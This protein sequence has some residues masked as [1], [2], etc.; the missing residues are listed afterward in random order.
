MALIAA[1]LAGVG[2]VTA[3]AAIQANDRL[4]DRNLDAA[5]ANM[6][7]TLLPSPTPEPTIEPSSEPSTE[8]SGEPEQT[9]EATNG[10]DGGDG[11]TPGE[12]GER[13]GGQSS[14]TPTLTAAPSPTAAPTPTPRPTPTTTPTTPPTTPPST[15]PSTAPVG[16]GTIE[17]DRPIGKAD[18]FF[19]VLDTAG[20][21]KASPQRVTLPGLPDTAAV[22]AAV[23]NGSD[24]RTVDAGGVRVRLLTQLVKDS[25]GTVLS[26]LQSGFVLT[27]NDEQTGQIMLT[28]VLASLIGLFGAGLVTVLVTRRAL[29]PIRSAF[30]AERRFVAAASHELRTPIAVVRA[31][32]EI[33]QREDLVKP[34]GRQLLEDV[35]GESDRLGRLVGDLL[36]LASAEAGAITVERRALE[37]R[38]FVADLAHRVT[39]M[40]AQRGVQIEVV[41]DG[42][43]LAADRQ[44]MVSADPDRMTQ[45]LLIFVDNAI[46]HSPVG[47]V[48]RLVVR[49]VLEGGR[50]QVMIGVVDQGPGVPRAERARIFEPFARLAGRRRQTGNT[51]LGLAIARLLAARQDAT[52]HVDDAS[53]GGAIFSVSL[54]RRLPGELPAQV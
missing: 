32:A 33:L 46:D 44:L 7:L 11:K 14:S 23:Q 48:V 39:G 31:S 25:G 1:L 52:L 35:V 9:A 50:P 13:E 53:G 20:R 47:G 34:E 21:V 26:V 41:Q 3:A 49:P 5:A 28:I 4:V 43:G 10:E 22:A 15:E 30:A 36:A 54:P 38:G 40:A 37:M 12:D 6:I 24:W 2:V 45:L 17:D 27:L 51:G 18:T 29:A 8:P 42:D 19:L 16:G